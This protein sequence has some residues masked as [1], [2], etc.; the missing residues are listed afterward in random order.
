MTTTPAPPWTIAYA[1]GSANGYLFDADEGGVHFT[2]DPVTA[3]ESSTGRYSGG[4]P[5]DVRL[6][7]DDLRLEM[8]WEH[9]AALEADTARHVKDRNKGDGALTITTPAGRR[10][11]LVARAGT[12]KLEDF[13]ESTFRG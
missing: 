11:L 1:D 4:D 3:A 12:R 6:A 10:Q 2:Y 5:V 13:L 8:L 9:V 7:A